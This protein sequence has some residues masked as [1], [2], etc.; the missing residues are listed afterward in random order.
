MINTVEISEQAK[1][2]LR[3]VPRHIA[4]RLYGWIESIEEEGLE[5]TRRRP[6]LHDE[7]LKGSR[8]GQRSI[9]IN[10][11]YRAIYRVVS[12]EEIEV[13]RVEEVNKHDY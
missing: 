1:K 10:R 11:A 12:T 8:E 6:G 4:V 3:R 9:R 7:P 2:Q 5:C 13:V